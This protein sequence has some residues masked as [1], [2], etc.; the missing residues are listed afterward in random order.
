MKKGKK[1]SAGWRPTVTQANERFKRRVVKGKGEVGA[2]HD[3]ES[4]A[5]IQESIKKAAK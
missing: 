4:L 2:E 3:G 5:S 1:A